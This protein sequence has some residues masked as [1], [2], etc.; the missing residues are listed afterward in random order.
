[1]SRFIYQSIHYY[2]T[3]YNKHGYVFDNPNPRKLLKFINDAEFNK[4]NINQ[5]DTDVNTNSIICR[6]EKKLNNNI[7]MTNFI[8][9]C[10]RSSI[11]TKCIR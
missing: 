5:P 10:I 3:F 11:I 2:R 6:P 8:S 9:K 1:M 7:P 4:N